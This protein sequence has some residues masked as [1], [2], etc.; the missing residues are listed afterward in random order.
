MRTMP[1]MP[2]GKTIPLASFVQLL[3]LLWLEGACDAGILLG[4]LL[5]NRLFDNEVLTRPN[6]VNEVLR[7]EEDHFIPIWTIRLQAFPLAWEHK[8]GI[9]L[10]R[11]VEV[12]VQR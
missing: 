4:E 1:T 11:K 10:R 12:V 3:A 7:Y 5:V 2:I 6:P 9:A 8:E